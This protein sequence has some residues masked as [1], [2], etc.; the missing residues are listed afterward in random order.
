MRNNLLISAIIPTFQRPL[1]LRNCIQSILSQNILPNELIIIDDGD[2]HNF[3]LESECKRAG[4]DC[5]LIKKYP[6]G[7]V[8]SRNFGAQIAKGEILFF[9]EDDI[10]LLPNFF[11]EI[12]KVYEIYDSEEIGGV[13][14]VSISKRKKSLEYV[15]LRMYFILFLLS[16]LRPGRVSF[17]GFDIMD[18]DDIHFP[19]KGIYEVNSLPGGIASYKKKVFDEFKFSLEFQDESGYALGEDK[20]FSYR[21]SRKYRLLVTTYAK[22]H[23]L[24]ETKIGFGTA[25]KKG[26]LFVTSRY[27]FFRKH[28]PK[29]KLPFF[30]Y[31]LLGY[32]L[33]RTLMMV[34][35]GN[36][37]EV[38][39]I[40]GFLAGVRKI[41]KV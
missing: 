35:L 15:L 39:R 10:V 1:E 21:V 3:P 8:S 37:S 41:V 9:L 40:K 25:W 30:A 29:S 18:F 2:L 23:H 7:V 6:K 19:R 17:S 33:W 13:G 20:E 36:K 27:K 24:K 14:G 34:S 5:I 16:G 32:F 26:F 12:L 11:D 38:K 28:I 31:S 4:I 22:V